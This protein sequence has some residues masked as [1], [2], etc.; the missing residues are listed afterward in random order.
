MTN[1]REYYVYRVLKVHVIVCTRSLGATERY[2]LCFKI[3]SR[4]IISAGS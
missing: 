4:I 2:F 3:A 1:Y